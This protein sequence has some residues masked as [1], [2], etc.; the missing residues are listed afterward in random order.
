[1]TLEPYVITAGAQ[2][3]MLVLGT[4]G[5]LGLAASIGPREPCLA[6]TFFAA[7]FGL[8]ATT[9]ATS[10]L[11]VL[12]LAALV[13]WR[14]S[15]QEWPAV[16]LAALGM[17]AIAFHVASVAVDLGALGWS[18]LGLLRFMAILFGSPWVKVNA[19][20]GEVAGYWTLALCLAVAVTGLLGRSTDG[21]G[22]FSGALAAFAL[23]AALLTA[24]G[25]LPEGLEG[26][27]AGRYGLLTVL[28]YASLIIAAVRQSRQR[29]GIV[30]PVTG[31]V[32]VLFTGAMLAE[33]VVIG[34][35]YA[36]RAAA[37]DALAA[38]VRQGR[39]D[40]DRLRLIYPD[41]ARAAEIL[42]RL[43]RAGLYGLG[44]TAP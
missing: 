7:L 44:P 28:A 39:L 26:A 40:P 27:T 1:V 43:G 22:A 35:R 33:Q 6:R 30:S 4:V 9:A 10:G 38:D 25:H 24:I 36:D 15:Y 3:L 17:I 34:Q 8:F 32:L 29:R 11:L 18:P 41:G 13:L 12:P 42:R 19:V 21:S 2:H 31:L 23:G 5:C 14:R 20:A 37:V 16:V